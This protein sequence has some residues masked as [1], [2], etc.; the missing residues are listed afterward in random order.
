M[1]GV[2]GTLVLTGMCLL[3]P[4][5]VFPQQTAPD[6]RVSGSTLE[7]L[8]GLG[9][10]P[11][12]T[13]VPVEGVV[14]E[15]EYIVGP[16]DIFSFLLP[17]VTVFPLQ[18]AVSPEGVMAIPNGGEFTVHGKTLKAV[19]DRV[20]ASFTITRPS[21]T[22]LMP[23]T[24]IVTVLGAVARPG[25]HEASA[26]MRVDRVVTLAGGDLRGGTTSSRHIILRR[27]S[28]PDRRVDVD[29]YYAFRRG[30]DNPLLRE[31]DVVIVPPRRSDQSSV[32]VYGG[33]NAP[34]EY[35]FREG[36]SLSTLI[37]IAQGLTPSAD[38]SSVEIMR[39][40]TNGTEAERRVYDG[41]A[42]LA[43]TAPDIPLQNKDRVF[44]RETADRRA[45]Y[46]VH[47]RGE[48]KHPGTYPITRDSTTLTEIIERS[49]GFTEHA[50]LPM[51]EVERRQTTPQGVTVDLSRE[52]L[53]NLRMTD[54]LVT[55]EER[56]YY[57]L[58]ATL[59][60]GTVSTDFVALFQRGDRSAEVFLRDGDVVFVPASNKTV[61]VYGQVGRPGYVAFKEGASLG[62]YVEMAGGYGEEAE[63]GG[64]R[65]IKGKTR[66]W[67]S[68]SDT[69]IEPGDY[70]W[71][72]KD[73]KYPAGYY[74]N[75]I[76]Q[77]ASFVSVVL[78]MT[79]II[80]Q[81]TGSN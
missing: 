60:R 34:G 76:S 42:V 16:G 72:P 67:L 32:S 1:K 25:N 75:L 18:V 50:F 36:D 64:A 81:L 15:E 5:A 4:P 56:A 14:D 45:D 12:L 35:E 8:S 2:R 78:S 54:Q 49:G 37:K 66:E 30:E 23:R 29:R 68:P 31:G 63:A 41:A 65:V 38:P 6:R 71:V 44:I 10:A 11:I 13:P 43:G 62:Y 17:G 27:G 53:L 22:L 61:Y 19:K 55:P 3:V 26:V 51:A 7:K 48:V 40:A 57:D 21:L 24:I 79:V 39:L 80:L 77:A 73:I 20:R 33:V 74:W 9:M 28:G 47:V 52:A 69:T 46:K 58:E 59:R 70:V